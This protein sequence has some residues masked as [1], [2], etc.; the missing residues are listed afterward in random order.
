MLRL[1]GFYK[2]YK[3]LI[4]YNDIIPQYNS[5]F[6]NKGY[7]QVKG[8]DFFWKD[9]QS[10]PNLQY[11]ISYSYTD[12]KK[13]ERNY[14]FAVQPDYL[15][16]HYFSVV[17]KYWISHLR[18]QLGLT[19]TYVSGRPYHDPNLSGFMQS[20]TKPQND[21]SF[22]WS[23]LLTQQKILFFSVT[24]LLGNKPIYTYEFSP[25][26]NS[27]GRFDSRAITPTAKRFL[28]LGFFWTISKNKKDNQLDQL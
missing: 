8:I 3:K 6:T 23:F 11:W 24:N 13:F 15:S 22:S 18:S 2:D 16:K 10:I 5:I 20:M 17:S 9:S 28:F 12:A 25:Q 14:E 21:L 26:P 19:N 4:T 7:G 27:N 1:E